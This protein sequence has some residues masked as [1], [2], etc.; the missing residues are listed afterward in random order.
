MT[1]EEIAIDLVEKLPILEHLH[2]EEEN[3]TQEGVKNCMKNSKSLKTL[4]IC[5][6]NLTFDLNGYLS[7]L[8][9]AKNRIEVIF[10]LNKKKC[11]SSERY[12][13]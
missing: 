7:I 12:I 4:K 11:P 2:I 6:E 8:D 3:T 9:L 13:A 10:R 5:V 1:D